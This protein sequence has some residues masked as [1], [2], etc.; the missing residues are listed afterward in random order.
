M[1]KYAMGETASE[2]VERFR[3][4]RFETLVARALD[5]LPP[6][7]VAMLDNVEIVVEDEPTPEQRGHHGDD[8]ATLF[9]LYE[10]IPLVARD[11]GYAMT[12][13]DRIII[14]R[15]PLERACRSPAEI[16]REVRITVLHELGHHFGFDEDR[17][18]ELGLG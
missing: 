8:D 6:H 7:I 14:F 15:R 5:G 4:R 16:A 17:L 12:L 10:G 11:A 9:G 2:R 18:E 3:R 13:P 1:V